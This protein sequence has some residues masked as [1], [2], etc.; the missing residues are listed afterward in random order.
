MDSDLRDSEAGDLV[1]DAAAHASALARLAAQH[2]QSL[3][4]SRNDAQREVLTRL[5]E[6]SPKALAP[7]AAHAWG[8]YV[9]DLGQRCVLFVDT[10]RQRGNNYVK[11]EQEDFKPVLA[12]D[13]DVVL[14]GRKL[15]RRVNYTLVRIRP[16]ADDPDQREDGRPFV[17]IDPRAGHG[18]GIGGFKSDS[19]VGVAL[20]DGHPVYFV[21]FY[22]DPE[23]GQ[24]LADV[25]AAEALFL[26]EV[27]RRHPNAPKP[28]VIGNCQGGWATMVL[29]AAHPN[30]SGPVVIAGAPLSYW[31]GKV[32]V[33]PMRYLGGLMGGAL[34]ALLTSDLGGG[35]FDGAN[36]VLNFEALNPG[37][38]WW[39]KYYNVFAKVDT[40]APRYLE[41]ERWWSGFYFMNEAEIRWIVE[42]LFIGNRLTRGTAVLDDGTALDLRMIKAPIVVFASHGDD[43]TPPQ[44]AL[45]WIA[46]LY[47]TTNEIRARGQV[48]IYTLHES[49]GHLGIFVSSTVAMKQ[50]RQITSVV[51]TIEALAPGLY[52]MR[53]ER[54][55]DGYHVSFEIR[56]IEDV[57]KLDD[58]REDEA[59]FA[60]VAR[61]SE[62]AAETYDMAVRPHLRRMID[63]RTAE[64]VVKG[65]PL[66]QVQYAFSDRNPLLSGFSALADRTRQERAPA[67]PDNPFFLLE[68][69]AARAVEQAWDGFR[70]ARD[71][72]MELTFR[73]IYGAPWVRALAKRHVPPPSLQDLQ[74]YPEV[75]RAVERASEGGYAEAVIRML[76]L[77]AFARGSVRRD[78]LERSNKILTSNPPFSTMSAEER[79]RIIHEQTLV[80]E[81]ARSAAVLTLPTLVP[82]VAERQK[83]LDLLL[84]IAGA[85]DDMNP[86]TIAMVRLLQQKLEV[87]ARQWKEPEFDVRSQGE[88][89]A[90]AAA[91][92]AQRAPALAA[93]GPA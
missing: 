55:D 3:M 67:A 87:Q 35:K 5:G 74:Q 45:N 86:P 79:A 90:G 52:E 6:V 77:I 38:S 82:T 88:A 56:Q 93:G 10:L 2:A 36:L 14:D 57:L 51:K 48:I 24:T 46:D 47:K 30:L 8:E 44:Q 18:S 20:K 23:P 4:Q 22:P 7:D 12:F 25:C 28:L 33:S 42:N 65:H 43:I 91:A 69:A 13:F 81:F 66:R 37:H 19:E 17:I 40:E 39:R 31:A 64:A 9:T 72:A 1:A 53:I 68:Q 58:G 80:V 61:M 83:A 92:A 59:D 85:V 60:P 15:Q 62:W 34:P 75:K 73:A 21:I 54:K 41:F 71:A 70:D 16:R 27:R 89:G 63:R 76:I 50:H 84:E 49:V 29:S 32:G 78:R 11:R 26:E